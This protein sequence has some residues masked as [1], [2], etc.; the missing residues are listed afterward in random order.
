MSIDQYIERRDLVFWLY[1]VGAAAEICAQEPFDAFDRDGIEVMIDTAMKL[2]ESHFEGLADRLDAAPAELVDGEVRCPPEQAAALR[3]YA[4]LGILSAPFPERYGG[5]DMPVTLAM[6]TRLPIEAVG[7][8]TTGYLFLTAAAANMLLV[9]GDEEQKDLWAPPLVSMDWFGTMMLSETQAGSSLGDIV[10]RASLQPDGTYHLRGS[11]MWISG[12][13]QDMSENIVHMVL[14]KVEDESGNVVP[15]SKGISLFL[16]P[17]YLLDGDGR[18]AERNGITI[19]GLNHKMGQ[20]GIVNTVPVLGEDRPC[21]GYLLGGEGQGLVGMFHMMNEAR[22]GIGY[23][24]AVTGYAGYRYSLD[25]ARERAQGRPIA[26]PDVTKPQIPIIEHADVK[27]M[28]LAQKAYTEGAVSLC[29]YAGELVD[30]AR[31]SADAD[32]RDRLNRLLGLLTPVVKSWPSK[33]ALHANYLAIQVLGGYGYTPDFPVERLY[34]DNRLNEIHEGTTGIQSLDLL[35]RKVFKDGGEGLGLWMAEMSITVAEA[36][37]DPEL[38][39]FADALG[40]AVDRLG[41][42]AAVLGTEAAEGRVERALANSA[43]F[44]DMCG[45]TAVAWMWLRMAVTARK[46]L[47]SGELDADRSFYEGKL[48]ACRWFF[49][50]ELPTTVAQADLLQSLEGTPFEMGEELF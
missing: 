40:S 25:Y 20:R 37:T 39:E 24:A 16:V 3:A 48:A 4:D 17:K 15:G 41:A 29:F 19:S 50:W 11:K 45:H 13:D 43:V 10:C 9:V 22:I 38:S 8:S 31:I 18:P 47:A 12:A 27:R 21:V 42:T 33:W 44:L 1:E 46:E 32:E 23:S 5:M 2:A 7:G 49:R 35:G 36:A 34:R 6:G 28:L 26:D 30:R 14:A